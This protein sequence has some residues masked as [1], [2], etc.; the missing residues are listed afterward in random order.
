MSYAVNAWNAVGKTPP[1]LPKGNL[2]EPTLAEAVDAS[3]TRAL[4]RECRR[5]ARGIVAG[6]ARYGVKTDEEEVYRGLV[7]AIE[8]KPKQRVIDCEELGLVTIEEKVMNDLYAVRGE[9]SREHILHFHGTP[10]EFAFFKA[11]LDEWAKKRI[12]T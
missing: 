5:R 11:R 6:H 12:S 9:P 4:Y 10:D 2:P 8:K 1:D 7:A 3:I